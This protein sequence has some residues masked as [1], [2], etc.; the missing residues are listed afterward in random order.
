[1]NTVMILSTLSTTSIEDLGSN[2]PK[3]NRWFQLYIFKNRDESKELVERAEAANFGALVL[4]VDAPVFGLRRNDMRNDF[5]VPPGFTANFKQ[6]DAQELSKLDYIDASIEWKDLRWLCGLTK[7][8]VLVKGIL[9][10]EDARLAVKN[11]AHG[12][13]VSNHGG[14]Q[15]D[16]APATVSIF[17][18]DNVS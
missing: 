15:L 10:P 13:I 16:S 18:S 6:A 17:A 12:I 9:T 5:K 11:G 8:P 2:F 4:T 14:R 3:L 7:L 1:M